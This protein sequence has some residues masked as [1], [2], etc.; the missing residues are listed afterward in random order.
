MGSNILEVPET[1]EENELKNY[2]GKL[3]VFA[4]VFGSQSNSAISS[5]L[6]LSSLAADFPEEVSTLD[7]EDDFRYEQGYKIVNDAVLQNL[8]V[9]YNLSKEEIHY[10]L[11]E[12]DIEKTQKIA[13][14]LMNYDD[15][16][17]E[18]VATCVYHN[19]MDSPGKNLEWEVHKI[20]RERG[21]EWAEEKF[22][23]I[24]QGLKN[25]ETVN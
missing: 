9:A 7:I 6:Y 4:Q 21:E 16:K 18:E 10:I 25:I 24:K 23:E 19:N 17:I 1:D 11:D 14:I 15:R 2:K 8:P 22:E 3:S 13:Q 5:A 12:K 20:K